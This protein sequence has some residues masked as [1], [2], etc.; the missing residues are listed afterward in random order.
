VSAT[1][2]VVCGPIG[3]V[4]LITPWNWPLNQIGAKLAPALAVGC[5]VVHKTLE[6]APLSAQIL[7]DVI[8]RAGVPAGVYNLVNG[9]GPR[10]SA[11]PDDDRRWSE[12][13]DLNLRPLP[14]EDS[15]LP[16]YNMLRLS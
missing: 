9:E 4:G 1:T 10:S 12:W 13:E 8:D 7:A 5:A 2:V 15:V 6:V 16:S 11:S 14:P 3:A